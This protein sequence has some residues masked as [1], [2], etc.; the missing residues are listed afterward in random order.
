M[1]RYKRIVALALLTVSIFS[2]SAFLA[3]CT[4]AIDLDKGYDMIQD[5]LAES[6]DYEVYFIKESIIKNNLLYYKQVNL[7]SE[8]DKD[9]K[10]EIENGRIKDYKLQVYVRERD[11]DKL[12]LY[13]GPSA[14]V[15]KKGETKDYLF[16]IGYDTT[17]SKEKNTVLSRSKEAMTV[18]DFIKT[19]EYINNYALPVFLGEL[20][21]IA[22]EQFVFNKISKKVYAITLAFT[23]TDEYFAS[24]KETHGTDSVLYGN[25]RIEL[26]IIY[27]RISSLIC[28]QKETDSESGVSLEKEP[29]QLFVAYY[30][31]K[32][33]SMPKYDELKDKKEL[34]PTVT[35]I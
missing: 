34:W 21:S 29:Y 31:E 15:N 27:G 9:Y 7:W 8:L 25:T 26:E 2:A 5:A 23:L 6:L 30:G 16:R 22:K 10:P 12:E 4:T 1:K 11:Y 19:D 13:C 20:A 17:K 35:L 32:I 33:Q 18:E 24:Y 28:Y 3:G 14:S